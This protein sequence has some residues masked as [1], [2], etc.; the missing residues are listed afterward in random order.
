MPKGLRKIVIAP[1]DY[2]DAIDADAAKR[3]ESL[4]EWIRAAAA[5]RLPKRVAKKLSEPREPGRPAKTK[6][7]S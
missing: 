1:P 2:W 5:L 4:S 7:T 3:G 6:T